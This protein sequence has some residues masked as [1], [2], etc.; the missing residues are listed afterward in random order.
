MKK[1]KIR[2]LIS[3]TH[4]KNYL[5]EEVVEYYVKELFEERNPILHG[6]SVDYDTEVNS[7]KK[8]ICLNNLI[9]IF[10]E[11]I[12]NIELSSKKRG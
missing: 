3:K 1:P 7:A 9:N 4:L 5:P 11:E 2:D 6:N 8:I 12:T 10:I